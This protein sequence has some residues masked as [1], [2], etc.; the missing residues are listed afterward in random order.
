MFVLT[1]VAHFVGMRAELIDMV[2]P[3]LPVPELLVTLTGLLELAGAAGLLWSRT[4]PWAAGGLA[5]LLV[6]M[7]PANVYAAVAGVTTGAMDQLLPRTLMQVV[8]VG[9]AVVVASPLFERGHAVR[10]EGH[11]DR[12]DGDTVTEPGTPARTVAPSDHGVV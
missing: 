3:A 4:A 1:G 10:D 8:F 7:F 12:D 5:A 11:T 2:P 6:V 9:A